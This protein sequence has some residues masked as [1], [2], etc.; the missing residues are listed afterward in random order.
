VSAPYNATTIANQFIDLAAQENRKLTPMQ[1]IKLSYIAHGFSLAIFKRALLKEGVEAWRYGPVIPGLYQRLKQ[2]GS[3]PVPGPVPPTIF[4]RREDVDDEDKALLQ[5]VYEKYGHFTG[6]Q[7]S[8]LT[9]KPGTPWHESYVPGEYGT[10][11][12]DGQ[13]QVH[14]AT[15]LSR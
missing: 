10:P 11:I 9:H 5:V 13:I 8:H 15:L 7:L 12:D 3:S 1:L 6:V 4:E 2:F 14:Y